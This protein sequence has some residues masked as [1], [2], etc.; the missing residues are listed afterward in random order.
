MGWWLTIRSLC[1]HLKHLYFKNGFIMF[2]EVF[3][4][5]FGVTYILEITYIL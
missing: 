2:L 4:C 5:V 3:M 1:V